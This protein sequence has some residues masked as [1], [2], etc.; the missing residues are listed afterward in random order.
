MMEGWGSP[1]DQEEG[2]EPRREGSP[3]R[4]GVDLGTPRAAD[5]GSLHLESYSGS[6]G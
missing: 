3:E 4:A 2:E 1:S 6:S 5:W